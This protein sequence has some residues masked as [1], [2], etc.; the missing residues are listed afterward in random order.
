MRAWVSQARAWLQN[1]ALVSV[2]ELGPAFLPR[3]RAETSAGAFGF[4][5]HAQLVSAVKL[6][7]GARGYCA[8]SS[9]NDSNSGRLSGGANSGNVAACDLR[10]HANMRVGNKFPGRSRRTFAPELVAAYARFTR[11]AA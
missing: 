11:A 1:R 3:T 6:A 7:S 4:R 9:L 5:H 10:R 2:T 8:S